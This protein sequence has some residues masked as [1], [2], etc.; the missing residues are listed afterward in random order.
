MKLLCLLLILLLVGCGG[1]ESGGAASSFVIQPSSASGLEYHLNEGD[2]TNKIIGLSFIS[3]VTGELTYTSF[4]IDAVAKSDYLPTSG[5]LQ[6]SAGNEYVIDVEIYADERIEGDEKL[7]LRLTSIAEDYSTEFTISVL[8]DD[9]PEY[10]V[11]AVD[12]TEGSIGTQLATITIDLKESTVDPYNLT[13]K[14]LQKEA[15]GYGLAGSDYVVLEQELV[16]LE[17]ELSKEISLEI[18]GD[19][20]IEPDELIEFVISH[21]GVDSSPYLSLIH[22]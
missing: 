11:T 10:T 21:N 7:G 18:F 4:N 8:N 17:G 3:G 2:I 13:L 19:L 22:I 16:F 20:D 14:T 9:F 12:T 15:V 5:T 6:V 1:A